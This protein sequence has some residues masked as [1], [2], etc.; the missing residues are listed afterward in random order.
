MTVSESAVTRVDNHA[1]ITIGEDSHDTNTVTNPLPPK[2]VNV[3]DSTT[4][5]DDGLEV[6]VGDKLHYHVDYVNTTSA[7]VD[8]VT[9]TDVVP[10]GTDYVEGSADNGGTYDAATKTV[11]WTLG[12]VAAGASVRVSF[13]VT[14][15][16]SA[17]TRVDNHATITIGE[18]SHDTNTVTNPMATPVTDD[19]SVTKAYVGDSASDATFTFTLT[20][21]SNTI[22]L[23]SNPMPNGSDAKAVETSVTGQGSS[24]FGVITFTR[25]GTYVYKV[26][27]DNDGQSG[28]TYDSE[29]FTLTYVVE[30]DGLGLKQTKTIT[31][32]DGTEV[33]SAKFTNTYTKTT[34]NPPKVAKKTPFTGDETP[35]GTMAMLV[36]SAGA[37]LL[38]SGAIRK[39]RDRRSQG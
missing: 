23:A 26:T 5:T 12:P 11:T 9:I 27:E 7:Q 13:A 32:A 3:N 38:V 25:P 10:T 33:D 31:K 24:E 1:T 35:M 16:E 8:S 22:G 18:D 30:Q 19:P 17:V 20:Q 28:W 2:T 21:V 29:T 4:P 14:V 37:L 34:P 15:S 36:L 6:K 39:R